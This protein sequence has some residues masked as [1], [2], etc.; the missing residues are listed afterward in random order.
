MLGIA[1]EREGECGGHEEMDTA[2]TGS[3]KRLYAAWCGRDSGDS[4][5]DI[6]GD[7]GRPC[8]SSL[9]RSSNMRTSSSSSS[10]TGSRFDGTSK[11]AFNTSSPNSPSKSMLRRGVGIRD[12]RSQSGLRSGE[13]GLGDSMDA[14]SIRDTGTRERRLTK[15]GYQEEEE[16][17]RETMGRSQLANR[18]AATF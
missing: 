11:I 7:V 1:G 3:C 16:G 18:G 12:S 13:V 15:L 10:A 2:S 6:P 5:R 9:R 4:E 17:N 14:D 8:S